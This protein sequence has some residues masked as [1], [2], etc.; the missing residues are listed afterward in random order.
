MGGC[1]WGWLAQDLSAARR[2]N[3]PHSLLILYRTL[4]RMAMAPPLTQRPHK[5]DGYACGH[6]STVS[7][8]GT[9][10]R[11]TLWI[12]AWGNLWVSLIRRALLKAKR[13]ASCASTT[14]V[15]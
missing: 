10:R 14:E 12:A 13:R 8:R 9:S 4:Q 15:F 5:R 7:V 3:M 2:W 1:T 6:G 11:L